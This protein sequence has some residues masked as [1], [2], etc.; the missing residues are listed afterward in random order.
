M[1]LRAIVRKKARLV[2]ALTGSVQSAS[3]PY[4]NSIT[5]SAPAIQGPDVKTGGSGIVV[6]TAGTDYF[7]TANQINYTD[8][9]SMHWKVSIDRDLGFN[10][11]LRIP[12]SAWVRLIWCGRRT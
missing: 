11:G 1:P 4:N 6:P 3:Y 9:Y 10:T 2:R 8:L 5:N 7:G 12:T